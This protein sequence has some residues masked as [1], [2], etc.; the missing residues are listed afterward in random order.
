MWILI[1]LGSG[2]LALAHTAPAPFLFDALAGRRAVWHMPRTQP[3]TIYL[4]FDDGPNPTTTPDLLDV[5]ARERVHATFFL[6]D[7][8]ITEQTAPLV[9]RMF[10]DG[11]AVALH[12]HTRGYM[13]MTP[14]TL[15]DTLTAAA[16]PI[17]RVGGARPGRP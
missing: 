15:A 14:E 12:S 7:R 13:V 11:H 3:P 5:L 9:R 16:D 4:T 1:A 6:I 8:H 17:E 2:I 10:A